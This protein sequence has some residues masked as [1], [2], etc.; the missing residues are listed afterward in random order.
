MIVPKLSVCPTV[1]PGA[2]CIYVH[3]YR[4]GGK[5][6]RGLQNEREL[7]CYGTGGYI[8]AVCVVHSG[9]HESGGFGELSK[10]RLGVPVQ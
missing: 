7:A 3:V 1:T 2:T 5:L 6:G 4:F 9:N 8:V 10:S